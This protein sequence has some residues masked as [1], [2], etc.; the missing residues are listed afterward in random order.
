[1]GIANMMGLLLI[2]HHE[3]HILTMIHRDDDQL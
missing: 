2:N 3:Y 1:M